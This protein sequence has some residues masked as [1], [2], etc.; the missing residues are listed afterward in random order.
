MGFLGRKGMFALKKGLHAQPKETE[1]RE[2]G[3]FPRK[4]TAVIEQWREN[5]NATEACFCFIL[6]FI[7]VLLKVEFF[8]VFFQSKK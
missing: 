8:K 1:R 5:G 4:V 3:E 6:N 2:R 7:T